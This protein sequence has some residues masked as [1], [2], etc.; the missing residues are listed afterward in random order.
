MRYRNA[1]NDLHTAN[2]RT[3]VKMTA[4]TKGAVIALGFFDGVH[5]GH[6]QLIEMA[7]KRAVEKGA[8]PA[9]LSFD[10]SPMS[11][12]T[13]KNV[14]LIGN[15]SSRE[16]TIKRIFGVEKVIIYHFDKNIMAMPWRDFIDS[17]IRQFSAVHFIIGHDFHCGYRGEG[18]P[19]RISQY[20]AEL[21]LGCDV[22]AEYT[23]D[24]ITVSSTYIRSLIAN[25]D[26][27]R[28]NLFLGHPYSVTGTVASGRK[29]GRKLGTP[30][31]NLGFDPGMV[32][33]AKG[34]YATRVVIDGNTVL[35]A[36]TNVG[37]RP[38]FGDG[39]RVS[40][41]SYILDFSGDLYGT[42]VRVDFYEFIRPERK[43]EG[44]EEL[45]AQI[46]DDADRAR[47]IL[48]SL[49]GDD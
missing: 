33:P 23:I 26:I 16:E 38:T 48:L 44:P 6:A 34:V 46:R 40:V 47:S 37:I 49:D 20:C 9:V 18:D 7:K 27:Q 42:F 43:F 24:G 5:R 32:L 35:P 11:V 29:V 39:S 10:V 17:L 13:G 15:V 22:I 19:E 12:V 31:I 41:E 45:G 1:C 4:D 21:G 28:A 3:E 14:P 36:V 25:G 2:R 8:E 30:T